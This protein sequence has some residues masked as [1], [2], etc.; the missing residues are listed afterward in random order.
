MEVYN[1]SGDFRNLDQTT[2]LSVHLRFGTI[3]VR[4]SFISAQS[5]NDTLTKELIW[6]EFFMQILLHFPNVQAH[7]FKRKYDKIV[8]RNN[9]QEFEQW[10]QGKTGYPI[11]DAGMRQLNE[12]RI[13]AQ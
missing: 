7:N 6:R 9:E 11:V 3:S 2:H 1:T 8:W 13:Y 5:K 4:N 12:T 10:C